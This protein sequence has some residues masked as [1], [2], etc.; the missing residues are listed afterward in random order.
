MVLEVI[1]SSAEV[2][3]EEFEKNVEL[4][5]NAFPQ[6]AEHK[7]KEYAEEFLNKFGI[8]IKREG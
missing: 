2:K 7:I 5:Y 3:S 8:K 6:V 4:L 1:C